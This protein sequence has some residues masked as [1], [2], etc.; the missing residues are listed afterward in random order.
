[1]LLFELNQFK[2]DLG[3]ISRVTDFKN[4]ANTLKHDEV[5][6]G[7]SSNHILRAQATVTVQ[8]KKQLQQISK[9]IKSLNVQP[10]EK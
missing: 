7:K 10:K 2:D 1:M 3:P 5:A 9:M 4:H 8:D 6:A